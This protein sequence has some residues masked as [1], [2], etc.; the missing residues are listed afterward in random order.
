MNPTRIDDWFVIVFSSTKLPIY[1]ENLETKLICLRNEYISF[2]TQCNQVGP[3]RLVRYCIYPPY[4]FRTHLAAQPSAHEA[5]VSNC[6]RGKGQKKEHNFQRIHKH[7]LMRILMSCG[8]HLHLS[9]DQYPLAPVVPPN[10]Q[11]TAQ[12]QNPTPPPPDHR[13]LPVRKVCGSTCC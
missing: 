9:A 10:H 12:L 13:L 8:L 1:F 11:T 6:K 3:I 5:A 7:A 2:R 4:I